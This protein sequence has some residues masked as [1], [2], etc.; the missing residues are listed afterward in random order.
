MLFGKDFRRS[1][2]ARLKTVVQ[3]YKH[4]HESHE[5]LAG[6][7]IALQKAVHLSAGTHVVVYLV[8]HTFLRSGER[9]R[10]V[11]AVESVEDVAH[12]VEDIATI[13]ATVLAGIAQDVELH[14]EQFF[15]L[16]AFA[17]LLHVVCGLGIVYVA[18]G[19]VARHEVQATRDERRKGLFERCVEFG[20][21]CLYYF[22]D[23]LRVEV[24]LLHRFRRDVIRLHS[25][26]GE[27]QVARLF[28]VGMRYVVASA[29]CGGT[30]EDDVVLV[31]FIIL[32]D[33][34]RPLEPHKVDDIAPVAEM[35]HHTFLAWRH[36]KLLETEYLSTQLHKRHVARNLADGVDTAPVDVLVWIIFQQVAPCVYAQLLA[37]QFLTVRTYAWQ[38]H[39]VL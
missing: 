29:V 23:G 1:H 37:E 8:H 11:L 3:G 16:E 5:R 6:T 25:H 15:E 33:I 13:L 9:E 34:L 22:S 28:Y 21:Q 39:Y 7:H 38:I 19:G 30:S 18:H 26:V 31:H 32:I 17:G 36:L 2:D 24:V 35:R 27:L 10:Q 12:T 4:G 20:E 14:I